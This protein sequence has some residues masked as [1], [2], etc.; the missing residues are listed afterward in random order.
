M[1]FKP[2]NLEMDKCNLII[3]A[4]DFGASREINSAI[5]TCFKRDIINSTT[6]MVNMPYFNEAL[7]LAFQ[8]GFSNK[9]GIH[10]NLTAGK[11]L[12]NLNETGL[13]DQYGCFVQKKLYNPS[14]FFSG[15]LRRKINQEIFA[16][17]E[18]LFEAKIKCTHI[19]SHH[20]V[21]HLPWIA[22]LFIKLAK[23]KNQKLRLSMTEGR[24]NF[25]KTIYRIG[26]NTRL[27]IGN[28][29]YT[30][31]FGTASYMKE[32]LNKNK[33]INRT[34]EIMVHPEIKENKL[35]DHYEPE[36]FKYLKDLRC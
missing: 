1:T 4:D 36:N 3:N 26:L 29:N 17:Y 2:N 32:Y 19:D 27:K 31:T 14:I 10:I 13:I 12:T 9:I 7:E 18:K 11:P 20:H 30:D 5:V 6:I 35:I 33:N 24:L 15:V 28:L 25:F 22:P 8:N 23:E 34:L 21:H 16:Q